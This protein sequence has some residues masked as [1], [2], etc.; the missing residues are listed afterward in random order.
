MDTLD[1]RIEHADSPSASLL[2]AALDTELHS[3][4]PGLPVNGIDVDGFEAAGGVF[5]VGYVGEEPAVCGALRPHEAAVE[6][7]RMFVASAFRGLGLG[8]RMLEFLETEARRRGYTRAVLETGDNQPEAISL[9]R[10]A[11]WRAIPPFGAYVGN[12]IST[13]FE[14]RFV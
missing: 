7:K 6:I 9:Y 14:K 12:P 4:Y 11:G 10:S 13:C 5:V 3:R 8:R 2:I 1:L